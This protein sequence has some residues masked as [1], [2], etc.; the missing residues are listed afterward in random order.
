MT[1]GRGIAVRYATI[2]GVTIPRQ[3]RGPS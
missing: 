3:S 1:L 2:V